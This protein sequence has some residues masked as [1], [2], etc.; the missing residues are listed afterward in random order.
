MDS[1]FSFIGEL[2]TFH[3]VNR[4]SKAILIIIALVVVLVVAVVFGVNLYV[5]SP[6]V[7]ARIQSQLSQ[8]LGAPIELTTMSVGWSGARLSGVRIPVEGKNFFEAESFVAD[9]RLI[10]LLRQQLVIRK[11]SLQSPKILWEP[12]SEGKWV[13]PGLP[14]VVKEPASTEPAPKAEKMEKERIDVTFDQIEVTD[15]S[16]ELV[17]AEH[18]RVGMASGVEMHYS[19]QSKDVISGTLAARSIEWSKAATMTDVHAQ[20]KYADGELAFSDLHGALGGGVVRAKIAVH[21]RTK[22]MP[23]ES[24]L[25]LDAVDIAKLSSEGGERPY[26][27]AGMLTG[28]I[29]ATGDMGPNRDPQGKVDLALADGQFRGMDLFEAIGQ[30]LQIPELADLRVRDGHLAGQFGDQRF[31]ISD[32]VLETSD[33]KFSAKGV[34][35]Y[36]NEKL[37][38]DA[39]LYFSDKVV[40]RFPS[41]VRDKLS[42]PDATGRKGL[43]FAIGGTLSRPRTDL[44]EKI[45]GKG[46]NDQLGDFVGSLFGK[47]K[48]KNKKDKPEEKPGEAPASG[49]NPAP[50]SAVQIKSP[51]EQ[52][53]LAPAPATAPAPSQPA[54]HEP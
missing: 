2:R 8:A 25:Q 1:H 3:A 14:K 50:E 37:K 9:Y 20:M 33:L 27:A 46:L 26:K 13:L 30:I 40:E 42:A 51:A 17:D 48:N 6:G 22:D 29:T 49:S 31:R 24:E 44:W 32:L 39:G 54:P 53:A 38:M 16:I 5:Q 15:G 47:K 45:I 19:M 23:Y 10:P 11:I 7:K 36:N 21:T 34:L 43:A 52:P 4:L 35:Q 18:H 28:S 41:F 12:N